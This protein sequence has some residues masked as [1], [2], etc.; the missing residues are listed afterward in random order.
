MLKPFM[1]EEKKL[2]TGFKIEYFHFIIMKFMNKWKHQQQ[3]QK[4]KKK[5]KR[6]TKKNKTKNNL[7]QKKLKNG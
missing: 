2:L 5:K 4:N 6:R 1:K 7:M 3:Q